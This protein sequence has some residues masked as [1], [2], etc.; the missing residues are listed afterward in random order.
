[1]LGGWQCP[2]HPLSPTQVEFCK[3]FGDPTKP[4]AWS[5]H[6]QKTSQSKNP[7][8][9]QDS[10]SMEP[11]KVRRRSL[12]PAS[13]VSAR[14]W[15]LHGLGGGSG[16]GQTPPLGWFLK[17]GA[18]RAMRSVPPSPS[19]VTLTVCDFCLQGDKMKK[20]AGELEKVSVSRWPRAWV[21]WVVL[22]GLRQAR[23]G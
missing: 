21:P 7:S 10:I 17:A 20:V 5:K 23:R 3:S 1:M 18:P 12:P 8:K 6:A 11:K 16:N 4:R 2:H 19:S 9:G 15:P 22:G 13:P 14:W